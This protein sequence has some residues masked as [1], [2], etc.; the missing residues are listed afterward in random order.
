MG[1]FRL[2]HSSVNQSGNGNWMRL[3][4]CWGSCPDCNLVETNWRCLWHHEISE[5][6][7]PA[8]QQGP[9]GI[10][11]LCRSF[12][13]EFTWFS[14]LQMEISSEYSLQGISLDYDWCSCTCF[15]SNRSNQI[16]IWIGFHWVLHFFP[17]TKKMRNG[18]ILRPDGSDS[19]WPEGC[20]TATSA[21][22][23]VGLNVDH[24]FCCTFTVQW[25]NK[26]P[27]F[28]QCNVAEKSCRLFET[29]SQLPVSNSSQRCSEDKPANLKLF[30]V[31]AAISC[32]ETVSKKSP[33]FWESIDPFA[34]SSTKPPYV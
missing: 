21:P 3:E 20:T 34:G 19:A 4:Q 12:C 15:L 17:S 31:T 18:S 28:T 16:E 27:Y 2:I 11:R 23:W 5:V 30:S 13:V 24:T 14:Q 29:S 9:G 10:P 8:A 26:G 7:A 1:D 22:Y 25:Q 6:R 32:L 33:V